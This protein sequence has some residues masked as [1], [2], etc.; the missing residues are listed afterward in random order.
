[1]ACGYG[2]NFTTCSGRVDSRVVDS[3]GKDFKHCGDRENWK[4]HNLES[5]GLLV[6]ISV[7]SG[8]RNQ[9]HSAT[10]RSLET[11][12]SPR[13]SREIRL[14][15]THAMSEES[16]SVVVIKMMRWIHCHYTGPPSLY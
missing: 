8:H 16:Q 3:K 15:V 1:M 11:I 14:R 9:S 6:N 4:R 13:H 12:A 7:V 2:R 10:P 5:D